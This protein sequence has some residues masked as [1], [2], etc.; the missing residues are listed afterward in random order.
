MRE[1]LREALD[2]LTTRLRDW[3]RWRQDVRQ[4]TEL[5]V[6]DRIRRLL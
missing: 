6:L 2:A 4:V 1:A 5:T 3:R